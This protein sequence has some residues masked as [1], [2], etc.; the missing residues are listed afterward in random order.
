[1]SDTKTC[2]RPSKGGCSQEK[3]M[4]EFDG[5][6]RRC[7]ECQAEFEN[8]G[9]ARKRRNASQAKGAEFKISPAGEYYFCVLKAVPMAR[10]LREARRAG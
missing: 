8:R 3:P 4:S 10:E 6:Q 7:R 2:I 1:M 5:N 9:A